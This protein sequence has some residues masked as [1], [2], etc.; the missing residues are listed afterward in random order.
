MSAS[1]KELLEKRRTIA[2]R[3]DQTLGDHPSV[4]AVY[5]FGSVASGHVD[6]EVRCGH[7][8]RV[9]IGCPGIVHDGPPSFV[10]QSRWTVNHTSE[11]A[12]LPNGATRMRFFYHPIA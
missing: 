4:T 11:A 7:R 6:G 5:V 10:R 12:Q 2:R 8:N 9:S 1:S 3:I